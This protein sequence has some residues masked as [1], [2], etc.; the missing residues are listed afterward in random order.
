MQYFLLVLLVSA[1][2]SSNGIGTDAGSGDAPMSDGPNVTWKLPP[3]NAKFDYQLG[4]A[5]APPEGVT[6]VSRDQGATRAA[7]VYN[8]CYLD[9]FQIAAADQTD[10]LDHHTDLILRDDNGDFVLDPQSNQMLLDIRLV[11]KRTAIAS[12]V[13]GQIDACAQYAYDA[14]E[15][16]HLDSYTHSQG[17][18]FEQQ[19]V[20]MM[21]LIADSAHAAG[22]AIAQRNA[23][24]LV[25]RRAEMGTDFAIAEGC[26]AS[27]ECGLYTAGYGDHVIVIEHVQQDFESACTAFPNLSIVLRDEALVTP[28]DAAYLYD[29]C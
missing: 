28:Q 11:E 7:D 29:G 14:I 13:A 1:C 10:W 9:G 4:G 20:Y 23:S 21:K 5:Y 25:A 24:A 3:V 12:I 27:D 18:L 26:S 16:G 6:V 15:I 17:L 8:I 19:T 2:G 22:R